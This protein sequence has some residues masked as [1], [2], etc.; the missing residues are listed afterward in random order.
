MSWA[1]T[2]SFHAEGPLWLWHRQSISKR[3]AVPLPAANAHR[4][5][6]Q[7]RIA[8]ASLQQGVT[9]KT[10]AGHSIGITHGNRPAVHFDPV[11]IK[12]KGLNA[13]P[14][15]ARIRHRPPIFWAPSVGPGVGGGVWKPASSLRFV[16]LPSPWGWRGGTS[17]GSC[18]WPILRPPFSNSW[19]TDARGLQ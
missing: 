17:V 15:P 3:L 6:R 1:Q 11:W 12:P 18:G 9:G 4:H 8:K 7:P 13:L 16:T 5:Q 10:G 2:T 14:T 19:S